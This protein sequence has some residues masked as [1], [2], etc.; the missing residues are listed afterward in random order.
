[1]SSKL[2]YQYNRIDDLELQVES[3]ID[4][5]RSVELEGVGLPSPEY[6]AR[7]WNLLDATPEW[8]ELNFRV[9]LR[10]GLDQIAEVLPNSEDLESAA[11]MVSLGCSA[12]KFRRGYQ[13]VQTEEGEWAT[14][15]HLVRADVRGVVTITPLLLRTKAAQEASG[16]ATYIGAILG[17]GPEA[18]LALDHLAPPPLGEFDYRYEV[19]A[20]STNTKVAARPDDVFF[21]DLRQRP[22]VH[23]NIRW[24][25]LQT[26]LEA[27]ARDGV[28]GAL[29]R[30]FAAVIGQD[31]WTQVLITAV[32]SIRPGEGDEMNVAGG[33]WRSD[34]AARAGHELFPDE[35]PNRRLQLLHERFNDAD[36][37]GT[38][39]AELASVAQK[40]AKTPKRLDDASRACE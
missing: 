11:P 38:L 37:L 28:N 4:A 27:K 33:D 21:L 35:T 17:T 6:G 20:Q 3:F 8:R 13:L 40:L 29:K 25:S 30:T 36:E 7:R 24:P 16:F 19:F 18:E 23:L 31:I 12:T 39:V 26:I 9:V 15:V 1:M 2:V 22:R 5:E 10:L 34:I 14:E 32:G